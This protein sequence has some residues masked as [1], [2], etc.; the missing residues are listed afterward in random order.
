M[1]HSRAIVYSLSA[2][3]PSQPPPMCAGL[4]GP[5]VTVGTNCH[6]WGSSTQTGERLSPQTLV[7]V[8]TRCPVTDF[9]DRCLGEK[10]VTQLLRMSWDTTCAGTRVAR[11]GTSERVVVTSAGAHLAICARHKHDHVQSRL[12]ID[13]TP[14]TLSST[15]TAQQVRMRIPQVGRMRPGDRPLAGR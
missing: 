3:S 7:L 2:F 5:A 14:E 9:R 11:K 8:W 15:G 13:L 1:T 12:K 4:G 10:T 6:V